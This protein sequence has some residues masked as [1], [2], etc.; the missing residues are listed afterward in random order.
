MSTATL[1]LIILAV[2]TALFIAVFQYLFHNKEKGQLN[3]WLSFFRFLTVFLTLLL[4]I[5]PSII[6]KK[7][8]I[9]KPALLI[10][11]DNSTSIKYNS[12]NEQIVKLLQLIKKSNALND[13][14]AISYYGFGTNL[15]ELD[16]LNFN[17]NQTNLAAPFQQFSK[18]YKNKMAPVVLISDGNQTIGN[19]I[20]FITYKNPVFSFIVGDTTVL[21]DIYI[22]RLNVNKTTNLKNKFPVELFVNYTGN[23]SVS[24][25]LI[26]FHKG[27]KVFS[28]QLYFSKTDNVKS[29]SFYLTATTKGTQYYTALIEEL[30]NE[31]NTLNNRKNFS[32]NVIENRAK[33][34]ILTSVLHPDLGLL[35]KSIESNKR[36]LV[37]IKRSAN[38]KGNVSDNQLIILY[39]PTRNFETVWTQINTK[40][41]NYFIITGLNT[42]WN[43][44]NKVQTNFKKEASFS[45]EN[46][47]PFLNASYS[48]FSNNNIDF[49]NFPP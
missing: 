3:Y 24:K 31:Q 13:K 45:S 35:K 40:K 6:K 21:E 39:Q 23:T 46:Y 4:L 29:E 15:H 1:L 33:I 7:V 18:L 32:I 28:K 41:L 44:L 38:F 37:S 43:F 49:N 22:Q 30:E 26:I 10:A 34:L 20:E 8:E 16:S 48:S 47:I 9:V 19:T 5:N 42:D 17:E 11:V 12:Q 14:Y 2:I 36:N 27:I 25:K